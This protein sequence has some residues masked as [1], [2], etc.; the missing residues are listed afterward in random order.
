MG[1]FWKEK[2]IWRFVIRTGGTALI[3]FSTIV[4]AGEVTVNI[5]PQTTS[6]REGGSVQ[7]NVSVS[8]SPDCRVGVNSSG[9]ASQGSD[10]RTSPFVDDININLVA[11]SASDAIASGSASFL[12]TA[13]ARDA[14][15]TNEIARFIPNVQSPCTLSS[16]S[17]GATV[18]IIDDGTA[19]TNNLTASFLPSQTTVQKGAGNTSVANI[20]FSLPAGKQ[21]GTYCKAIAKVNVINGGTAISGVD[22]SFRPSVLNYSDGDFNSKTQAV[23]IEVLEGTAGNKTV[24]LEAVF[25]SNGNGERNSCPLVSARSKKVTITLKDLPAVTATASIS[26]T[27][28]LV[29]ENDTVNVNYAISGDTASC[30]AIHPIVVPNRTTASADQYQLDTRVNLL[31]RSSVPVKILRQDPLRETVVVL[32]AKAEGCNLTTDNTISFKIS[33]KAAVNETIEEP[34]AR[35]EPEDL[36]N[37]ACS[38]LA[39]RNKSDLTGDDKSF[40]NSNCK[41]GDDTRNFEPEE[42]SVQTV[43]VIGSAGRLLKNIR[44]RLTKLRMTKGQRGIDVSNATL[45]IQGATVSRGLLGGAAGDDENSLLENSR[46]GFFANGDYAF[47]NEDRGDDLAEK[48][49]DRNFDFNSTGLTFGADY[50]FPG[51]KMIAGAALGYKDFDSDFTTQSGGTSIKGYNLSAYGTYLLSD[52]A[53]LDATIGLGNNKLDARRPVNNDG[54]RGIG[55]NKTFA[56]A[57]PDASEFVFSVGGGYEFYK[58]EWSLTPYGR[59]DYIKGTIDSYTESASHVSASTS[60]FQIDKQNVEALTSTL[61]IKASRVIST[62]SGVFVPYAS[63]EWKHDFKER[64]AILGS[65]IYLNDK[66]EEGNRSEFDKNYYNL[67]VG[68]SA[69][70]PKGRSAFLSVESR[71]GDS[72]VENTAIRAGIRLEF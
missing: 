32:G 56:I 51:E 12:F 11:L 45:N 69:Q 13:I 3:L 2:N 62:S 19:L 21:P 15:E 34:L 52:K 24:V 14:A 47:G 60:L 16:N 36:K 8:G 39:L 57:K 61:G 59:M 44:S 66:F 5:T 17:R 33:K 49:G 41:A 40:F 55:N 50:R 71:Q 64:G 67:G 65:S 23:N 29:K 22:F 20:K 4:Y 43:A 27:A 1:V 70:F 54:S 25:T 37:Q 18:T 26:A 38:E 35:K 31:E 53:Y 46:W 6:V 30:T 63:A 72:V 9:T 58:G 42:V 28:S 7:I 48:G 68:V 10:Y